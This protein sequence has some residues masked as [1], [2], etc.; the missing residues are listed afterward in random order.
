[1]SPFTTSLLTVGGVTVAMLA[2]LA[3]SRPTEEPLSAT[4]TTS[5]AV[6]A[7]ASC[8]VVRDQGT[9]S[10]FSSASGSFGVERSLCG[11]AHGDFRASACPAA[12]QVGSCVVADGEVKRYY[13]GSGEHGFSA[14]SAKADC[15]Q[16]GLA[17]RFVAAR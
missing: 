14:E 5:A 4:T 16:S 7:L 6:R 15:E 2:A 13:A 9:C 8:D 10:D 11:S 3:C 17:G 1:M 12:G